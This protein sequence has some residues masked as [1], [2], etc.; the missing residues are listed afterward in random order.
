MKRVLTLSLLAVMACSNPSTDPLL[1]KDFYECEEAL[2]K[3]DT[4]MARKIIENGKA[5]AKDSDNYYDYVVLDAKYYFYTM[6][7]DSFL[8]THQKIQQY[9]DR[10]SAH[11][12]Q[13]LKMLQVEC[14]VQQGV[15][16]AKMTGRMD[17]ALTHNLHALEL[18]HSTPHQ[19][20]YRLMVL[21]NIADVYK[22]M[23]QYDKSVSYY[24]QAMELGDS[25]NMDDATRFSLY[26]AIASAYAAMGSFDQSETWWKQA[27][28]LKPLME[29]TE[30]FHY[31]NNRG[32]DYY[33]QER[34]KESLQ[35][36]LELDS[37][38]AGDPNLQWERMYGWANMSDLYINLK[39]EERA[40]ELL[41]QTEPF[42]TQQKQLI[43]LF[44][45]TTQRI[46]LAILNHNLTE[47]RRLVDENPIPE[48]MIPEQKQLRRKQLLNLY[49]QTAQWQHYGET[50]R[51]YT[52]M[53]DSLA[54]NNIKMRFAEVLTHYQHEH[55]LLA[56]Q[57]QLEAKDLSYRWALALLVVAIAFIFMLVRFIIQKQREQKL[58]EANIR[59]S[60]AQLHME[61]VRNRITPHFISNVLT[62]EMMAQME[63]REVHLDNL[64]HLLH[65]G[66]ELT[67]VEQTTLSDELEFIRFYCSIES[68]S[69]GSDFQLHTNLASDI[70][71]NRVILPSMFVQILV[72]NAIKHGLKARKPE[73][74][75]QRSIWVNVSTMDDATLVEVIDNGIGLNEGSIRKEHTGLRIIRQ[76]IRLLNEQNLRSRNKNKHTATL[77]DFGLA[78]YTQADGQTGCRSWLLLPHQFEYS[79][80]KIRG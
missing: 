49:E 33:L 41:A 12:R 15:Y 6:Q 32:N 3:G 59:G 79:L 28:P 62:A 60:M 66:I 72:E 51:E 22:Q 26:T 52:Q 74:G 17:S 61:A 45:L 20:H 19:P 46:E 75:Q 68:R 36:F 53:K 13:K 73:P 40:R 10:H 9:V 8:L 38:M 23:G 67:D 71:A 42:F 29:R 54:S 57:K 4:R 24:R 7:A 78:N 55:Q 44:Y 14:E 69:I 47:A 63:G 16:E 80:K 35:C 56:K 39:Q 31:L 77:M 65:R 27:E 1:P 25:T 70:D 34:Y 50:L 11:H 76:T 58:R 5:H 48:W 37:L 21:S 2:H 18:L 43:P 30:L 64:V